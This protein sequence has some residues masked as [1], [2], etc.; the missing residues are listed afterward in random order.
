M[1]TDAPITKATYLLAWL[2]EKGGMPSAFFEVS[3]ARLCRTQGVVV[4]GVSRNGHSVV[5]FCDFIHG[6]DYLS[7]DELR[8]VATSYLDDAYETTVVDLSK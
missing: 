3:T 7:K 5:A 2:G 1:D 6:D 4:A 8:L